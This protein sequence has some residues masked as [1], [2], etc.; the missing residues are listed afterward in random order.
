MWKFLVV[1][2]FTTLCVHAE[3][4]Q[5]KSGKKIMKIADKEN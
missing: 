3:E 2:I 1:L 4:E 5:P